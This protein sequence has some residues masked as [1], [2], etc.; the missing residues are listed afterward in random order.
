M[1]AWN[2]ELLA[3]A[4]RVLFGRVDAASLA[5]MMMVSDRTIRRWLAG[6]EIPR[7]PAA[8]LMWMRDAAYGRADAA[9]DVARAIDEAIEGD[10]KNGA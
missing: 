6:T 2:P 9:C 5:V 1:M 3:E 10:G 8:V 4:S 7:D